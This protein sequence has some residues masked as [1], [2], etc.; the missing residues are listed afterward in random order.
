MPCVWVAVALISAHSTFAPPSLP[1]KITLPKFSFWV[2]VRSSLT[3]RI[4]PPPECVTCNFADVSLPERSEV[5]PISNLPSESIRIFSELPTANT[6]LFSALINPSVVDDPD[7]LLP[8]PE[9][10]NILCDPLLSTA[11]PEPLV[12]LPSTTK[13]L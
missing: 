11:I 2:T 1:E 12:A 5:K 10:I 4:V 8:P 6:V 7:K 3:K 13:G 9:P